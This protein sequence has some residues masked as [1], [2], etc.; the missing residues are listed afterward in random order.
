MRNLVPNASLKHNMS[1]ALLFPKFCLI[2]YSH[3]QQSISLHILFAPKPKH[4]VSTGWKG[5]LWRR[6]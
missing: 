3:Q 6:G 4:V 1:R 5:M 2:T